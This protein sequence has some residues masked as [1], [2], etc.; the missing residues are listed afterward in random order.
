MFLHSGALLSPAFHNMFVR[1]L[2][3]QLLLSEFAAHSRGV[4]QVRN[5]PKMKVTHNPTKMAQSYLDDHSSLGWASRSD[6]CGEGIFDEDA[7]DDPEVHDHLGFGNA[8]VL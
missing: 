3:K 2:W 7:G 6:S 1:I 5:C 8:L 4:E